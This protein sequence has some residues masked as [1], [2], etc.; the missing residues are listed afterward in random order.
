MCTNVLLYHV[1]QT[2]WYMCV[3]KP[4]SVELS[5]HHVAGRVILHKRCRHAY[6]AFGSD[7]L[8]NTLAC[9]QYWRLLSP[10]FCSGGETHSN[11]LRPA[12]QREKVSMAACLKTPVY[13]KTEIYLAAISIVWNPLA[14]DI[15]LNEKR[16]TVQ[17]Q[18][19]VSFRS[20]S[21][22]K[23]QQPLPPITVVSTSCKTIEMCHNVE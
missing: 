20:L 7:I 2:F 9:S 3:F 8:L 10:Q 11:A 13:C 15:W 22:G 6:D 5:R 18:V 16:P 12:S 23:L 17:G 4:C 14:T 19:V 1:A 21:I